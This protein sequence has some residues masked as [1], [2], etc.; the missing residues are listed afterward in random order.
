VAK[1][2]FIADLEIV[3]LFGASVPDAFRQGG[4]DGLAIFS[5]PLAEQPHLHQ[6]FDHMPIVGNAGDT[7]AGTQPASILPLSCAR[8]CALEH[9][10]TR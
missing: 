6:E 2:T 8:W 1:L 9:A 7:D 5:L 10:E 4:V 3:N